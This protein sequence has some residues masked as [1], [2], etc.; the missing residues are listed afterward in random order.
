MTQNQIEYWKLQEA[1]RHNQVAEAETERAARASLR[2]TKRANKAKEKENLRHN[3]S[4]E[5]IALAEAG[6]GMERNRIDEQKM[7]NA[8]ELGIVENI[9]RE[10]Y[11]D[12][13]FE[14]ANNQLVQDWNKA[15]LASK[16][17]QYAAD[18]SKTVGLTQAAYNREVGL[19]SAR[20]QFVVGME[21]ARI[22]EELGTER[23]KISEATRSDNFIIQSARNRADREYKS[24]TIQNQIVSNETANQR[25]K[26][27]AT[28][29]AMN[30][31]VHGS[32][33]ILG[34]AG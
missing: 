10:R 31:L 4:T 28:I 26:N 14:L 18:A 25:M 20:N 2:E 12:R 19:T 11:N 5:S 23:N 8:Y 13:Y 32:T 30:A 27:D 7:R 29:G 1:L 15:M 24:A 9:I 22:N 17:S 34:F 6:V 21:N 3:A 33:A 16:T